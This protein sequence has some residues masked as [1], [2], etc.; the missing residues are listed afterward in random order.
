M[1][2]D[3]F[4]LHFAKTLWEGVYRVWVLNEDGVQIASLRVIPCLPLDESQLPPDAPNAGPVLLVTVDMAELSPQEVI[5]WE[6]SLALR[7]LS[8]FSH[9]EPVPRECQFFYPSPVSSHWLED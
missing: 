6:N 9:Q 4:Q 1:N 7:I 3:L 8:Q 5:Q 2:P